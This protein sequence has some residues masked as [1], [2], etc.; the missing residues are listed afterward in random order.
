VLPRTFRACRL[1]DDQ[2]WRPLVRFGHDFA[3]AGAD[4]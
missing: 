1:C 2:L 4:C 3:P